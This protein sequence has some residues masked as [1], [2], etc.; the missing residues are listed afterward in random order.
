MFFHIDRSRFLSRY[1]V[2]ADA[3]SVRGILKKQEIHWNFTMT[4]INIKK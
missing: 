2:I 1:A 3:A 4:F